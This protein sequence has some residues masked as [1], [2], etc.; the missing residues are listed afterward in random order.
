MLIF[1]ELTVI[2]QI[3][4]I[5]CQKYRSIAC[6]ESQ[7]GNWKRKQK[8]GSGNRKAMVKAKLNSHD[9]D[10]TYIIRLQEKLKTKFRFRSFGEMI[11]RVRFVSGDKPPTYQQQEQ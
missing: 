11:A 3:V 2:K 9:T 1:R 10:D 4:Q 7:V 6:H 5:L 8:P